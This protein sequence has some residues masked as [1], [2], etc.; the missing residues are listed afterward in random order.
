MRLERPASYWT[1]LARM[2]F[3]NDL[4]RLFDLLGISRAEFARRMGVSPAYVTQVLNGEKR[5]LQIETLVKFARAVDAI[6]QIRLVKEGEEVVRVVDYETAAALDDLME[7]ETERKGSHRAGP[8]AVTE[9]AT[10]S[11]VLAFSRSLVGSTHSA[12]GVQNG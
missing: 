7:S 5:N 1:T 3:E 2:G 6:L 8:M 12:T 11:R 9:A 10:D 4:N